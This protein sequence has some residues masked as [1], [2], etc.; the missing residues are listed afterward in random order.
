M[1]EWLKIGNL[2]MPK[3][4]GLT[5]SWNK[6][7]STNTGRNAEATMVGTIKAIKKKLEVAFVP[8]SQS[9]LNTIRTAVN[10]IKTPYA[11]VSYQLNSGETDS[12]TAYTGD[13]AGQLYIDAP[14]K[15]IYKDVKISIIEK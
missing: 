3:I 9:E 15:T 10:N 8:L 7:W 5:P 14:G 2:K 4:S 1:S 12:F 13:L 6:V 11:A